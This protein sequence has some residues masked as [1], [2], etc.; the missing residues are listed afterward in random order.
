MFKYYNV[1]EE[2]INSQI[3]ELNN[4]IQEA[5]EGKTDLP[6]SDVKALEGQIEN[7]LQDLKK[8]NNMQDILEYKNN[9]STYVVK[10]AKIAGSLSSAGQYINDLIS[11]R[12]A[13]EQTLNDGAQYVNSTISGVVSYRID[14]LED[15]LK[16]DNLDNI[17]S[18]YLKSLELT[19]GQIVGKNENKA[20]VINN[21]KCYIA[22]LFNSDEANNTKVGKKVTLRLS[23]QEK[24]KA[25]VYK[26]IDEGSNKLIIFE[27]TDGVERLINYR[28]IS[29][30]VIWWED[31]GFIVPKSSILYENG[32]SYV[33]I[34]KNAN[35]TKVL[36]S[37]EKENDSYC[38]IE[39]YS[40]E[41]LIEFGY[42]AE[43]IDDMIQVKLYDEIIVDPQ[44][45]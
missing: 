26:I 36:V 23:S 1:D 3:N 42:T 6:S 22:I 14:G 2:K 34:K 17:N 11:Q 20:K 19:T 4:K 13:L 9:I 12:N 45:K 7:Q 18:D 32:K 30:D 27:I 5:L 8:E 16:I 43:E 28:K 24:V 21:F 38:L 44:L 15:K 41:K 10:K 31:S 37:V 29:I 40:T 39:N 35:S 33:L 25:E